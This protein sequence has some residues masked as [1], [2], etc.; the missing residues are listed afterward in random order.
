MKKLRA[1]RLFRSIAAVALAVCMTLG[2][3]ITASAAGQQGIDVSKYQGGIN[4]AAVAGSG[5]S[6][7]FIKVGSTKSGVDP[8]FAANVQGAQAA[9]IR[10]GVYIYS[11]ATSVEAAI[12]EAQLVLQWI[13]P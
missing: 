1:S 4:W 9:G 13:E 7:A 6:Y 11:Y 12:T 8:Y 5:V 3:P 10:T 2:A